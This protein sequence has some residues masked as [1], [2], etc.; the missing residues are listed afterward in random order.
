MLTPKKNKTRV[1]TPAEQNRANKMWEKATGKKLPEGANTSLK[2]DGTGI[3]YDP[4]PKP[5]KTSTASMTSKK[6]GGIS[7]VV[8]VPK[9]KVIAPKKTDKNKKV[10]VSKLSTKKIEAPT[11][12]TTSEIVKQSFKSKPKVEESKKFEK[13]PMVKKL[14]K[15]SSPVV[16]QNIKT[17]VQNVVGKAKYGVQ[18]K[19]AEAGAKAL[20]GEGTLMSS[21]DK[22]AALREKKAT[23]KSI[24]KNTPSKDIRSSMKEARQG[25]RYEKKVMRGKDVYKR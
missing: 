16:G 3:F 10:E 24:S 8:D 25:I 2:S 7:I 15:S 13:A 23:L 22:L 17:A 12:K 6:A 11:P 21:R 1:L 19:Q 18:K 14:T 20:R 5:E 9:R 4:N